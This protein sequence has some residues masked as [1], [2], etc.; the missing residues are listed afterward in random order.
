MCVCVCVWGRKDACSSGS[1]NGGWLK[2]GR[3]GFFPAGS[4]K[5][6]EGRLEEEGASLC[7]PLLPPPFLPQPVI[8][9]RDK[10]K[11]KAMGVGGQRDVKRERGES[12]RER[13]RKERKAVLGEWEEEPEIVKGEIAGGRRSWKG[14][15]RRAKEIE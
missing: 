9:L 11:E 7:S 13:E 1:R 15:H 12:E 4:K 5:R 6:S 14:D 3:W 10:R 8:P 2:E